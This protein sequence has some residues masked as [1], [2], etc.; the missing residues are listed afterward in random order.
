MA[1]GRE[2]CQ[3]AASWRAVL[4]KKRGLVVVLL[5]ESLSMTGA[6]ARKAWGIASG[7]MSCRR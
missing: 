5:I 4:L 1:W 6:S 2:R 3:L 7:A